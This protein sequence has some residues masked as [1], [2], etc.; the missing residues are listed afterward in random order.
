MWRSPNTEFEEQ[1]TIATVKHGSGNIMI[2]RCMSATGVGKLAF[3]DGIITKESYIELLRENLPS[4]TEKLGLQ[5]R[6]I[7]YQDNKPKHKA[8][9]T[10]MWLLFNCPK[11]L[12]TAPQSA[13]INLIENLWEHL[14]RKV[15]EHPISTQL[16][17]KRILQ[18][19]WEKILP[20]YTTKLVASM[21]SR[22]LCIIRSKGGSTRY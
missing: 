1:I 14:D 18:E 12:D 20:D 4:S 2:W 19:E 16:E 5:N 9:D 8:W 13:D 3:I 22:L 6:Y 11:V 21:R 15:R 10:R 17:L 7:L